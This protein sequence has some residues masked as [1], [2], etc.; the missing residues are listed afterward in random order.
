MDSILLSLNSR[1]IDGLRDLMAAADD[2]AELVH[3]HVDI[4]V[5]MLIAAV[6]RRSEDRPEWF[7]AGR[8]ATI[9]SI[10]TAIN[11]QLDHLPTRP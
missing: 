1:T 9:Q 11:K 3:P 8:W 4:S 10:E 6:A 7:P 2:A 5:A